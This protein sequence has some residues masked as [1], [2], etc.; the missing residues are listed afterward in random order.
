M[1][2]TRTYS[3]STIG[4]HN[5]EV[6]GVFVNAANTRFATCSVD[7]TIKI[8]S[9]PDGKELRTLSGHLGT[10]NNLSFSGN[11]KALASTSTD[12]TVR[13]WDVES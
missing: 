1:A 12:Q 4:K 10:V 6:L 8:W 9:L 5:D 2:Q 3:V 7:E 13:I 11:D